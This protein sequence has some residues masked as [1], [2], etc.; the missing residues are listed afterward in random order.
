MN[1]KYPHE[2]KPSDTK[3][4]VIELKAPRGQYIG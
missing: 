3:K 1:K 2:M 4:P